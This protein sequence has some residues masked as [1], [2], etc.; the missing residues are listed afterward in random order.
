MPDSMTASTTI[1]AREGGIMT[2]EVGAITGEVEV[3]TSLEGEA[4]TT[5]VRYAGAEEWYTP[6]GLEPAAAPDVEDAH[7]QAVTALGTP[8]PVASAE[9]A[10]DPAPGTAERRDAT[11]PAAGGF[12][13][14]L[15]G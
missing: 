1:T 9:D 4:V 5:R 7:A 6:E 11:D 8:A 3:V 12:G 10:H 13:A 2:A 15:D 14:A